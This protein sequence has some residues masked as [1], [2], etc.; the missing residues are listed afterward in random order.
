MIDHTETATPSTETQDATTGAETP[1][2]PDDGA[3]AELDRVA[4]PDPAAPP[5]VTGE[6]APA[7]EPQTAAAEPAAEKSPAKTSA[8]EWALNFKKGTYELTP[9]AEKLLATAAD[10]VPRHPL[11][12]LRVT[13]HSAAEEENGE[14]LAD[15]RAKMVVGILVNRYQVDSKRIFLSSTASGAGSKVDLAFARTP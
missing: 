5:D 6:I 13:G 7:A 1:G 2:P 9:A 3:Q 4:E 8:S 11:E 12:N 15:K 14:T 10:A